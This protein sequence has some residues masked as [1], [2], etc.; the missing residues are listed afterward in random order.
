MND[1]KFK[2]QFPIWQFLNQPIFD[3]KTPLVLNPSR[4]WQHY[5]ITHLE[6][7]WGRAYRP[8]QRFRS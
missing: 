4:F 7:C 1:P 8:E 3:A 6:R 5:Q 2:I